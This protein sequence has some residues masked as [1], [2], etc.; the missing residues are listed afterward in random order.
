MNDVLV[1]INNAVTSW[2]KVKARPDEL[3]VLLPHCLQK[4]S[5]ERNVTKNVELCVR[6]GGCGVGEVLERCERLGVKV[7]V[8]G[9]GR[10]A[11][12]A[13]KAPTVKAVV[14][15]ACGKEL[16]DG[17]L[18]TLPK[19]VFAVVNAK[20]HGPCKDTTVD[21]ERVEQAIKQLLCSEK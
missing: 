16:R 5:C 1:A 9:G 3:L 21:A 17:I 10:Q 19:P 7:M 6:C 8:A 15:V 18:A 13:V 14:A 4:S 20:P 12:A 2:R 11:V